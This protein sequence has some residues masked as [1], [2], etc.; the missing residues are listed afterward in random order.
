MK[1]ITKKKR[2]FSLPFCLL[3]STEKKG[4][5]KGR[6][7]VSLFQRW[8]SAASLQIV[9][10]GP[11]GASGMHLVWHKQGCGI[12]YRASKVEV[13]NSSKMDSSALRCPELQNTKFYR[14]VVKKWK[15]VFY[16]RCACPSS[17]TMTKFLSFFKGLPTVYSIKTFVVREQ[18]THYSWANPYTDTLCK[19]TYNRRNDLVHH[20]NISSIQRGLLKN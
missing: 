11:L 13:V 3:S 12:S 10:G 15:N 17:T 1:K 8:I 20:E 14:V 4:H 6:M 18:R 9:L 5:T 7:L 19:S 2:D 16:P